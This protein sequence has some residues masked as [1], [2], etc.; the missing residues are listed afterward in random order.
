MVVKKMTTKSPQIP[1]SNM[2]Q[3]SQT[4]KNVPGIRI[5]DAEEDPRDKLKIRSSEY[6]PEQAKRRG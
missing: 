3:K 1:V 2:N 4:S 5:V 6:K